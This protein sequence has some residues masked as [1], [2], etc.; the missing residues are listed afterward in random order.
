MMPPTATKVS[1]P[2]ASRPAMPEI[3]GVRIRKELG[4]QRDEIELI[5]L[6]KHL[7]LPP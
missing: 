1:S 4:R 7:S 5:R 6:G 3:F 2:K